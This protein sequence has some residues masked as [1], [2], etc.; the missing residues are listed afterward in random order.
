MK[1]SIL[2]PTLN[3]LHL[4]K[5][6]LDSARIQT[7]RNIE[8]LVSDDGSTDGSQN[9]IREIEFIDSRVHLLSKN[10][11]PGLFTN[12]NYLISRSKGD[13]F[14]ILADDDR[15]LA[16]FVDELA[17][18]LLEDCEVIASF[19]DH[20]IINVEGNLLKEE[21]DNNSLNYGRTRLPEGIVNDPLTY[22]INGTMCIGF[23]LY[24][25]SVFRQE[26]FDISC[27]G[28]ADVDYSIRASQ[29]GK[30]YY[31]NKRLGEYRSHEG[32]ISATKL[33][34]MNAGAIQTFNK[35]SFSQTRHE[36]MRKIALLSKYR[37]YAFYI[38][39]KD[40]RECLD[41]IGKYIAL[42]GNPLDAKIILSLILTLLPKTISLR[43][44]SLWL[45]Q[46]IP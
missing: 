38:C 4:L 8:I 3:R 36:Q 15:L 40:R 26:L 10:P 41:S 16:N 45:G 33:L 44:Q 21:S 17:K 22:V 6:S 30:L 31:I 7:Y 46:I 20:W 42:R 34:Y 27:G 19:C 32:S 18:P 5:Q 43:L 35:Y 24:R 37:I 29:L 13:A 25:S 14:C 28:A 2:L 23:S 1:I 39:A 12:I 9:F 11:Q